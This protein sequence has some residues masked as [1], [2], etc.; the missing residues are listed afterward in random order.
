M[1]EPSPLPAPPAAP[2]LTLAPV[3]F[4]D[5]AYA[6]R[7][8]WNALV[9]RSETGTIFQTFEW[10]LSWWQAFGAVASP[11]VVF[12]WSAGALVGIAPLMVSRRRILARRRRLVE[13]IGTGALGTRA[14][15]YAD[16]I[17][18]RGRPDVLAAFA[19]WLAAH[20]A[21]WDLLRLTN[22]PGASPSLGLAAAFAARGWPADSRL[23]HQAPTRVFGN[24]DDDAA[25]LRKKSLKRHFNGFARRGRLEF[26]ARIAARDV[27]AMLDLLFDQHIR[28][29]Q[30]T[31]KTSQFVDPRQRDFFRRLAANLEESGW[32]MLSAVRFD[33][34][35]I[36][37]HFGFVY[38]GRLIWYKP[39]FDPTHAKDSP[40]EVLIKYLLEF[41][42]DRKLDE[43][44]FTIGEE[45]FKYRFANLVRTTHDIH[46]CR[47]RLDYHAVRLWLALRAFILGNPALAARAR[48]WLARWQALRR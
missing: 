45:A 39:T 43:L 21:T 17:I 34:A 23:A 38:G 10:H 27:P 1:S 26:V 40:G 20:A 28:R 3:A 22:I 18:D 5:A 15:D 2:P 33:D 42:I 36:A 46:V 14:S 29:W 44:D 13:F 16:F 9:A 12:A 32:L 11:L 35:V 8:E 31:D 4:P 37:L 47:S 30:G 7:A 25:L 48:K 24:T 19:D 41:A 6:R